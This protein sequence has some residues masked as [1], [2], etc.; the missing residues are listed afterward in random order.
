MALGVGGT[1]AAAA[2]LLLVMRLSVR[3]R[4]AIGEV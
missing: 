3:H 1:L 4:R 2:Y